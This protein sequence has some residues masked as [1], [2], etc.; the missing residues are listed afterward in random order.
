MNYLMADTR[1]VDEVVALYGM[2]N[3]QPDLTGMSFLADPPQGA[4]T[5][6]DLF[7]RFSG[8]MYS[9]W[10]YDPSQGGYLRYSDAE[11]RL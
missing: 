6:T 1:A 9:H 4:Q 5:G 10:Q 3:S 7:V 11:K 8:G 2:D